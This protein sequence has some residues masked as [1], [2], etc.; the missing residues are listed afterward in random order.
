MAQ[1]KTFNTMGKDEN[2]P[3]PESMAEVPRITSSQERDAIIHSNKIV[4]IDYYTS[5]CGPCTEAAPR[6]AVLAQKLGRPGLCAFAKEDVEDKCGKLPVPIRGVPCFHF[7]VNGHYQDDMTIT[8]AN[9][10]QIDE[11]IKSLLA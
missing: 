11:T 3:T 5:W 1:Y 9:I 10:G 2:A 6:F 7:Y 4:V 8:G